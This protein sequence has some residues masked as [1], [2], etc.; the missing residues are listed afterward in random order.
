MCFFCL[1]TGMF[2]RKRKQYLPRNIRTRF[3]YWSSCWFCSTAFN[4][5]SF[6]F[7]LYDT[8]LFSRFGFC[9]RQTRPDMFP[10]LFISLSLYQMQKPRLAPGEITCSRICDSRQD[11][12]CDHLCNRSIVIYSAKQIT[13]A[14]VSY[15]Q[16][17]QWRAWRGIFLFTWLH[18]TSVRALLCLLD[19]WKTV[20]L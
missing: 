6:T 20:M 8:L 1:P 3:R 2:I 4:I 12:R 16:C 5:Y 11:Q 19:I 17:R 9:F 13:I 14:S 15:Y 18:C 7:F 10:A